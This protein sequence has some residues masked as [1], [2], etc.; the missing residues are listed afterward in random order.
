MR[1][2]ILVDG[3]TST[4]REEMPCENPFDWIGMDYAFEEVPEAFGD[5]EVLED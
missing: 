1:K 4:E 3:Y 2:D 5:D